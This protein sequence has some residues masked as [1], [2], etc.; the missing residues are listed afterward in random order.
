[1]AWADILHEATRR[2]PS[3]RTENV[4][5]HTCF[6]YSPQNPSKRYP[7]IIAYLSRCAGVRIREIDLDWKKNPRIVV[8][9]LIVNQ[10]MSQSDF[11]EILRQAIH[12][13]GEENTGSRNDNDYARQLLLHF[14]PTFG[15]QSFARTTSDIYLVTLK[16]GTEDDL[17][18]PDPPSYDPPS[19]CSMLTSSRAREIRLSWRQHTAYIQEDTAPLPFN[20]SGN[21]PIQALS[22]SDVLNRDVMWTEV[23]MRENE[24]WC[25]FN[26]AKLFSASSQ[27]RR[28]R[29]FFTGLTHEPWL[30]NSISVSNGL[31]KQFLNGW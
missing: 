23:S 20:N 16:S 24:S 13:S 5:Y 12:Q 15:L 19:S 22:D 30:S 1:M 21:T 31:Q 10:T 26:A 27:G 17:W 3:P 9:D 11:E 7:P 4:Y 18:E 2:P 29:L 8:N 6:V 14:Q 25:L 28:R